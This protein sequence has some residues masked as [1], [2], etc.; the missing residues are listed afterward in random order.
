MLRRLRRFSILCPTLRCPVDGCQHGVA[1]DLALEVWQGA[2]LERRER[3]LNLPLPPLLVVR[4]E[5]RRLVDHRV[6]PDIAVCLDR[7]LLGLAFDETLSH[8]LLPLILQL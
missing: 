5:I 4:L 7:R 8:P 3:Q 1:H 2:L 6:G